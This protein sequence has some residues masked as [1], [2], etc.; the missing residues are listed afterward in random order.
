M[1]TIRC[2]RFWD[3][4]VKMSAKQKPV[5]M[6]YLRSKTQ[7]SNHGVILERKKWDDEKKTESVIICHIPY[8]GMDENTCRKLAKWLLKQADLFKKGRK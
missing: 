8:C 6:Q 4:E 1:K 3:M 5:R 2:R 7:F